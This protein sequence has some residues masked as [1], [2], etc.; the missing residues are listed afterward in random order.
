MLAI[1]TRLSREDDKST[2]IENQIREGKAFAKKHNQQFTIYNEGEGVS[3]TLELSD[4]PQLY[5][6]I[7]DIKSGVIKSVWMRNQNRL[8]RNTATFYL[9]V[10]AVK[11][12]DINVSFGDGEALDFNDPTTLLQ[13]S[14]ISSL[15]QY[16]AQLQGVQTKKALRD[17]ASEGK[18]WAVIPYG[19][20]TDENK[21]I[22][23]DESQAETVKE[24]FN[25]SLEGWGVKRISTHLTEKGVPT[26]Y[27]AYDGTI[28]IIN[29][30]NKNVTERAKKNIVWSA[31]TVLGIL[32]NKWYIGTRTYS[33]VEYP[34]PRIIDNELFDKVQKN[35]VKNRIKSSGKKVEY[36]YLLKG[37]LTCGKCGRNYYGRTRPSKRDNFYMCSSKRYPKLNCGN[38]S[39][40]IPYLET[41]IIKHLFQSKDLLN[42]LQALDKVDNSLNELRAERVQVVS[43]IEKEIEVNERLFNLLS[44]PK[45]TYDD[46][47]ISNYDKS[48]K[49]IEVFKARLQTIDNSISERT[50]ND[51]IEAYKNEVKNVDLTN[52]TQLKTAINNIVE[53][54]EILSTKDVNNVDVYAISIKYK[55]FN[56]V[57]TFYTKLPYNKWIYVSNYTTEQTQQDIKDNIELYKYEYKLKHGVEIEVPIEDYHLFTSESGGTVIFD[58]LEITKNELI[59]FN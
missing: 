30:H 3:G 43:N 38:K 53:S 50:N 45:L 14:I 33:G 46:K 17:S 1:Y 58:A 49:Q 52:F 42:H 25:L 39:I 44:N 9:F 18:A 15:N 47:L 59:E 26:K 6:L 32:K 37:L 27:N 12:A 40:S 11:K 51:R 54:I 29:K 8:D 20:S 22:I 34:T 16:T 36:R 7:S 55:A 56:E 23:I 41:F 19:Y 2:S 57:S 48:K 28:K 24:I 5:N 4:R 21:H 10:S 31:K 13:T 35:L